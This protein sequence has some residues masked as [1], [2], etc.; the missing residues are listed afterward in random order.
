MEREIGLAPENANQS[1]Q[2][3]YGLRVGPF[4]NNC[5]KPNSELVVTGRRIGLIV[6]CRVFSFLSW[7]ALVSPTWT[8]Y[9]ADA[10]AVPPGG[11]AVLAC[12]AP[13][14]PDGW[15]ADVTHWTAGSLVVDAH[16]PPQRK[17][18]PVETIG[19][20]VV[21]PSCG[22]RHNVTQSGET[23]GFWVVT[24]SLGRDPHSLSQPFEIVPRDLGS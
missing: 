16:L 12:L 17:S 13:A 15:A 1:Q 3:D 18:Q 22:R 6:G 8:V 21:T 7:P 14:E 2:N 20:W 10:E 4:S 24:P 9:A 19:F 5:Q 11:A 23:I